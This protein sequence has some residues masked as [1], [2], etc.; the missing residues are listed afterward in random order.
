MRPSRGCTPRALLIDLGFDPLRIHVHFLRLLVRVDDLYLVHRPPIFLP[1]FSINGFAPG[2]AFTALRTA[3][4]R[5]I[6]AVAINSLLVSNS[7][8]A[9]MQPVI[10]RARISRED[11]LEAVPSFLD[12]VSGWIATYTGGGTVCGQCPV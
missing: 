1:E 6:F 8:A 7:L 11:W 10:R 4:S 2:T 12:F 5:V 9:L 3:F